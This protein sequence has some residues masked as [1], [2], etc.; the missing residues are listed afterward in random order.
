MSGCKLGIFA[1][2]QGAFK[3]RGVKKKR[4]KTRDTFINVL[5]TQGGT[6]AEGFQQYS[7]EKGI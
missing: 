4:H 7:N 1:N 3:E 5:H 6:Q 2:W